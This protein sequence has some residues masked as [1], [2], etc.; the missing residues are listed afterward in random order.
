MDNLVRAEHDQW[1][2]V[3]DRLLKIGAVT[4]DDLKASVGADTTDGQRILREIR[5]WGRSSCA[6]GSSL[7]VSGIV[8]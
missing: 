1:R 4:I 5:F 7:F 6:N 2:D 3:C 8:R